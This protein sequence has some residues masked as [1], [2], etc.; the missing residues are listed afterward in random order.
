MSAILTHEGSSEEQ[1]L[2]NLGSNLNLTDEELQGTF[3]PTQ[4]EVTRIVHAPEKLKLTA[5][6]CPSP[7]HSVPSSLVISFENVR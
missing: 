3:D 2:N 1:L 7:L 6:K 4:E 5:H